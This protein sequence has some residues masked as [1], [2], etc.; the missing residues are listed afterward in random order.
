[1]RTIEEIKKEQAEIRADYD[2]RIAD[3]MA[4]GNS[5][6]LKLEGVIEE[7]QRVEKPEM[8]GVI[9]EKVEGNNQEVNAQ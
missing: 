2:K 8:E 9:V 1:M 7:L 4:E 6:L 3:L 5:K